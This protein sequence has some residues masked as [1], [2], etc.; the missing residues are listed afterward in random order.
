[1]EVLRTLNEEPLLD[2]DGQERVLRKISRLLRDYGTPSESEE[3]LYNM[4]QDLMFK[5]EKSLKYNELLLETLNQLLNLLD[6]LLGEEN[7]PGNADKK[8]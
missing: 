4:C 6:I 3:K 1:M 5:L 2:R 8:G 7:S